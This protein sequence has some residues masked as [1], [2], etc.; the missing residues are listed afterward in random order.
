MPTVSSVAHVRI[1]TVH[2]SLSR[3][4]RRFGRAFVL[5]PL[6]RFGVAAAC[7]GILSLAATPPTLAGPLQVPAAAPLD[8]GPAFG[9]FHV[10]GMTVFDPQAALLYAAGYVQQHHAVASP[11]AVA[12]A[13][14][15]LYRESG[16]FLAEALVLVEPSTGRPHIVVEEGVFSGIDVYGVE[17]AMGRRIASYFRP[18]LAG[19]PATQAEFERALMLARDLSGVVVRSEIRHDGAGKRRLAIHAG[20]ARHRFMAQADHGPRANASSIALTGEFYSQATPGDMARISVGGTRDFETRNHGVNLSATYRLPVGA[21]GTYG[22]FL[23]ANTRYGRDIAGSLSDSRFQE[24]RNFIA[25]LGHPFLRNIHEFLY[26]LVEFDH[27]ELDAGPGGTSNDAS[28]AVRV[29]TYYSSIG[30]A[31][32]TVRG[33]ATISA[34]VA[35]TRSAGLVDDQFWHARAGAGVVLHLDQPKGDHALRIE[36]MGQFT[37]SALPATEKFYLGDRDRMRGYNM[38]TTLGDTG[39][40]GTVELSRHVSIEKAIIEAISPSV[41]LDAGMAK[42]TDDATN[43]GPGRNLASVG[44]ATRVFLRDNLTLNGWLALPLSEDGSGS[45]MSPAGYVRLTKVW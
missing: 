26:G 13:I 22:E 10:S 16:Y 33:G 14:Q 31:F 19:N 21:H 41:F 12:G 27:A 6:A 28:Q 30:N 42:T 4:L 38:A 34:G 2:Q 5:A 17:E 25:L 40:A 24:G 36:G 7:A 39:V 15:Y 3:E 29:S 1:E 37:N 44:I 11:Q 35:E 20:A 9:A 8:A 43:R 32:G 18:L 45:R 23:L